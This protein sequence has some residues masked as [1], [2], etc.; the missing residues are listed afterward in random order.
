MSEPRTENVELT[1]SSADA[2]RTVTLQIMDTSDTTF[3]VNTFALSGGKWD[4]DH[5]PQLGQSLAPG[6]TLMYVNFTD[7]PYT[8]VGGTLTLA[9]VSG[10]LVSITWNW[11]YGAPLKSGFVVQG[12]SLYY[13]LTVAG[14]TTASPTVQISISSLAFA[15]ATEAAE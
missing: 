9:P 13:V 15:K 4:P 1:A 2:V 3:N 14:Q 6:Q 10:G 12:T 5:Q 11:N 8:G 7:A